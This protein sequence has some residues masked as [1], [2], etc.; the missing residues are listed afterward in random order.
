[1]I[2]F[3]YR[4]LIWLHPRAFRER[5]GDQMLCVFDE[6]ADSGT[7][8]F[9]SDA[10][11]SLARQWLIR[12]GAWRVA[13][14]AGLTA[15]LIVSFAHAENNGLKLAA[16]RGAAEARRVSPLDK[17]VFNRE[18]AQAVAMLARF[19]EEDAKERQRAKRANGPR[20][21]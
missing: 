16:A 13:T 11:V 15:G 9:F 17:A 8:P 12:S 20:S 4:A 21:E 3:L 5:F 7:A 19:R 14:G 18:A 2:R 10:L 6:A 1:M